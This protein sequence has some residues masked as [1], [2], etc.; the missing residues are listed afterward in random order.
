MAL[1][2]RP[3]KED[4]RALPLSASM[5]S[6]RVVMLCALRCAGSKVVVSR[7]KFLN[8]SDLPRRMPLVM[9]TFLASLSAWS[10]PWTP[11]RTERQHNYPHGATSVLVGTVEAL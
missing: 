7:L 9:A 4:P 10:F 1:S 6:N 2:S 3:F 11:A 8:T 5:S